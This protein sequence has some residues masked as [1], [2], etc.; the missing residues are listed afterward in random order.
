MGQSSFI[1]SAYPQTPN[2]TPITVTYR[3]IEYL[4]VSDIPADFRAILKQYL[5]G[6]FYDTPQRCPGQEL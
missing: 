6:H 4:I 3:M 2:Q 5:T 1:R